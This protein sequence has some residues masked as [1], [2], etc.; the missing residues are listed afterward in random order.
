M[1]NDTDR[2]SRWTAITAAYEKLSDPDKRNYYDLHGG[3]VPE[4]LQG[5]DLSSLSLE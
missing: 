4:D 2:A 3:D 1:P 5:L